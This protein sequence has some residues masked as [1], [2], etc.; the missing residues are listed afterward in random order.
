MKKNNEWFNDV[1]IDLL[2]RL[3]EM[4]GEEMYLSDIGFSLTENEN[5]DDSWYCNSLLA[6]EE[7]KENWEE[8][9]AIAEYMHDNLGCSTN[10]LLEPEKF[11]CQ[12]MICLYEQV[13]NY[14]VRDFE[15]WNEQAI[16]DNDLIER[17][18]KCT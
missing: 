2:S 12:A 10:P 3:E 16:I 1:K 8:F 13:F 17:V 18:K 15:K 5:M 7:I 9:G 6:K 11:H 4:E 14:A